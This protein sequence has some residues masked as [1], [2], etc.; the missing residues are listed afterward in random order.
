MTGLYTQI[1]M[2]FSLEHGGM[3]ECHRNTCNLIWF[4]LSFSCR[5]FRKESRE[6][7]LKEK[8]GSR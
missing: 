5:L 7:S 1:G 3:H 2:K 6:K 4:V 8:I